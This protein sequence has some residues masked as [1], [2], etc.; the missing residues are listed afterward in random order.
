MRIQTTFES[1]HIQGNLDRN[2]NRQKSVTAIACNFPRRTAEKPA[3]L[4]HAEVKT[5]FHEF[6]HVLHGI[7]ARVLTTYL[8]YLYFQ[9]VCSE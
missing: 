7:L 4:G 9:M 8:L 3:L 6:G 5:Y 1:F 2:G